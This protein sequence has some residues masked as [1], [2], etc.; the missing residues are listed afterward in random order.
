MFSDGMFMSLLI[1]KPALGGTAEDDSVKTCVGM[2]L[3][4]TISTS[5][6]GATLFKAS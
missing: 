5:T 6:E 1:S 4:L 2:E 3:E